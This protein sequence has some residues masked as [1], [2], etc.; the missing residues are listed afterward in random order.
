LGLLSLAGSPHA[1]TAM[2]ALS[3]SRLEDGLDQRQERGRRALP[4][5]II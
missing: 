5:C 2:D 1:L 3:C 4:E